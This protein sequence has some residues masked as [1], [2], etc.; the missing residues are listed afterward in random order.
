MLNYNSIK[1]S[2]T[3]LYENGLKII[4]VKKTYII[5]NEMYMLDVD[6]RFHWSDLE[7]AIFDFFID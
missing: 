7:G 3:F 1:N 2:I 5:C 6:F 4:K